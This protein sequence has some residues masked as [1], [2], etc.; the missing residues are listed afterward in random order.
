MSARS[1]AVSVTTAFMPNGSNRRDHVISAEFAY[2]V[3][4]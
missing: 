3:P 4:A 1:T 2:A